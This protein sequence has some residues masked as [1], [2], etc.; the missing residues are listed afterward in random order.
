[1]SHGSNGPVKGHTYTI[2]TNGS[3]NHDVH[4][5]ASGALVGTFPLRQT[6]VKVVGLLEA[7]DAKVAGFVGLL[8]GD[9]PE[10]RLDRK[11]S[12][13]LDRIA[14]NVIRLSDR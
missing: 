9:A 13:A 1:M 12:A 4:L 5:I 3:E 14:G 10:C 6:A 8:T 7:D 11:A 2:V